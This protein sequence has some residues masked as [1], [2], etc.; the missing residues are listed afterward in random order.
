VS[1]NL[2]PSLPQRKFY[3]NLRGLGVVNAPERLQVEMDAERLNYF[4]SSEICSWS[5][6]VYIIYSY[7]NEGYQVLPFLHF[8]VRSAD[9]SN[10]C[11]VGL[12]KVY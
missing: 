1:V 11:C 3:Q 10:L 12:S 4:F 2:D 8:C 6:P 9:S 5:A 7:I